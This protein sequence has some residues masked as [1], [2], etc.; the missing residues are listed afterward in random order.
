MTKVELVQVGDSLAILLPEE[1]LARLRVKIGDTLFV[2]ESVNGVTLT[3]SDPALD[4]QL[5]TALRV[6]HGRRNV[7]DQMTD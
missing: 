5:D 1:T 6:I 3:S 4:E 2:T 7:L